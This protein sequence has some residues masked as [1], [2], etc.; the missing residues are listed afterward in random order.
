VFVD[1]S[2]EVCHG[3]VG[4][5][6]FDVHSFMLP[7]RGAPGKRLFRCGT[8]WSSASTSSVLDRPRPGISWSVSSATDAD[9]TASV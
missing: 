2:A 6:A 9:S 1:A 3:D 4:D 8:W 5:D 7:A